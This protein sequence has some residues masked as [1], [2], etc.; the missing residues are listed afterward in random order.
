MGDS[1]DRDEFLRLD[2]LR[3]FIVY[4]TAVCALKRER[5]KV[6]ESEKYKGELEINRKRYSTRHS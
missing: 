6:L 1:L 4:K 3:I 2:Q 5:L